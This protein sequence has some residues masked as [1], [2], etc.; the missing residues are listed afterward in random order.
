MTGTQ[1]YKVLQIAMAFAMIGWASAYGYETYQLN[2]CNQTVNEAVAAN[3][4]RI[5]NV[6]LRIEKV[7]SREASLQARSN[8][9][10]KKFNGPDGGQGTK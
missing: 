7:R 3:Q 2:Q 10:I 1:I 5:A 9:F 4:A 6:Q 8:D